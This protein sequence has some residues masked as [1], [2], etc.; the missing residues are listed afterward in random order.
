MDEIDLVKAFRSSVPAPT[1]AE[2]VV[3]R[4][5]LL[6]AISAE[7]ITSRRAWRIRGP[8]W[9]FARVV[10]A[11]GV[12]VGL[13]LAIPA[14][15]PSRVGPQASAREALLA[16]A[17]Q[18]ASN[19]VGWEAP[20]RG[21]YIYTKIQAR[22][23][24]CDH[25]SCDLVSLERETWITR[26]GSGR[27]IESRGEGRS[28]RLFAAGGLDFDWLQELWTNDERKV[29]DYVERR[30]GSSDPSDFEL[31]TTIIALIRDSEPL[32]EARANLYELAARLDGIELL[33]QVTDRL[34][35][36]GI[37]F[38]FTG[39]GVRQEIILDPETTLPLEIRV[40]DAG[41]PA[42]QAASKVSTPELVP[43][44]WMAFVSSGLVP[45]T[46]DRPPAL[47][48]H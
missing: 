34:G 23:P 31:F 3:A 26:D 46:R 37:G 28:D 27:V 29:R 15:L 18:T 35:R 13:V 21:E 22:W 48:R 44:S 17:R 11:L 43:G 7:T 47:T 39:S 36:V 42:S 6:E 41:D 12:A 38:A 40:V 8:R 4:E 20:V 9:S 2:L 16:I 32:P 45:S 10:L 1:E 30:T 5:A 25:G 14:L 24:D 33:G 19:P